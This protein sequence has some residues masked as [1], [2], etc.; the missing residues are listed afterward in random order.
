MQQKQ[1]THNGL[2]EYS[3]PDTWHRC[4]SQACPPPHS[5]YIAAKTTTT[6]PLTNKLSMIMTPTMA[7]TTIT[8]PLMRINMNVVAVIVAAGYLC[9]LLFSILS[10]IRKKLYFLIYKP[11]EN[12]SWLFVKITNQP[13]SPSQAIQNPKNIKIITWESF[14]KL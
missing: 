5:Y 14:W 6:I 8:K 10:K 1:N 13:S 4:G 7:A 2:R 12:N 3:T 9:C 11:F